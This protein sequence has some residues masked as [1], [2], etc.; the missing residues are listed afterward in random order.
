MSSDTIEKLNIGIVGAAGRGGSFRAGVEATEGARIHAVCD[1]RQDALDAAAARLGASEKYLNYDEML[2]HSEVDAVIIGTPMHLHVPQAVQA[3]ARELHVLSE[4]TAAVTIEQ[5]RELVAACNASSAV[6]MMAENTNYMKSN[7]LVT[8]LVRRGMFGQTYYAEA[9]YLHDLKY[10]EEKTPW[11]REWQTGIRGITYGTH[12]LGPVLRWMPGDR[13]T[14]V[15]C[16]G[17]GSHYCDRSGK[18]YVDDTCVMLAKTVKGALIKIRMDML[19]ERPAVTCTF[20]LQGTKGAYESERSARETPKVWL[21]DICEEK[22]KW[23]DLWQLEGDYMPE[24]WRSPSE[25]ALRAGHGGADYFAVHDF[26]NSVTGKAPCP[27]GIHEAMDMTL[28]GLVSQQSI[29]EDGAWLEV[30]DSRDW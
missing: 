23:I 13:V 12:S 1:I 17:S 29:L 22:E 11:R 20:Q 3:L 14:R 27:I 18:P 25:E 24:I 10:Y 2:E 9:E 21:A 30:P 15:C 6:Y 19:S 28:P 7:V 8:E 16:E 4:V 5:C 26:V